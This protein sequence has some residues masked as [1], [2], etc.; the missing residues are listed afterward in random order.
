MLVKKE[1][2]EGDEINGVAGKKRGA[3]ENGD[4]DK[5]LEGE[6]DI[7]RIRELKRSKQTTTNGTV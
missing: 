1:E 5:K 2:N 6:S 3:T 4:H 7:F